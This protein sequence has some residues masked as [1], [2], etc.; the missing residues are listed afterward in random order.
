MKI[1]NLIG[2]C[3]QMIIVFSFGTASAIMAQEN[4]IQKE[5]MS[6]D[7]CLNVIATSESKLS[8]SPEISEISPEKR[9]AIFTLSDGT[10]TISCDGVNSLVTVSTKT[11]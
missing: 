3:L 4:I 1:L 8:I 11:N 5:K 9:I 10:L 6:F 7:V 2:L